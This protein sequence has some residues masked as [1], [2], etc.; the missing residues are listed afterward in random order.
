MNVATYFDSLDYGPAPEA[1]TQ[2]REWLAAHSARFGHFIDGR[3][4]DPEKGKHFAPP[5]RRP[6]RS[7]P[8]LHR[9]RPP[10]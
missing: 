5:N 6:A 2:A 4:A 8:T 1:D 9:A 3:F 10:M 7:W